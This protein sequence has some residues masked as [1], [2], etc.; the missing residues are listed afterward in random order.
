MFLLFQQWTLFVQCALRLEQKYQ[1]LLRQLQQ[2]S[3]RHVRGVSAHALTPRTGLL[4]QKLGV[5]AERWVGEGA[6]TDT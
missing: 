2:Q 3:R 4:L 1:Y 5:S 6:G